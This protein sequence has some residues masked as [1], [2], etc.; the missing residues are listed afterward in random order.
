MRLIAT[1]TLP[2][3]FAQPRTHLAQAPEVAKNWAEKPLRDYGTNSEHC[4]LQREAG[5]ALA[6]SPRVRLA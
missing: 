6:H 1:D 3:Q 4:Q 5:E 2:N